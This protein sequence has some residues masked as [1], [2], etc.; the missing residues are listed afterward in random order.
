MTRSANITPT[1]FDEPKTNG[2][3]T[4]NAKSTKT[5]N[6]ESGKRVA[7]IRIKNLIRI[8]K[9]LERAVY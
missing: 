3:T 2:S 5:E 6:Y 9:I 1:E 4:E 8:S 7:M